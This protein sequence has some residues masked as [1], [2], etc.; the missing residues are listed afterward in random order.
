MGELQIDAAR[1]AALFVRRLASAAGR[2]FERV[3]RRLR[4]DRHPLAAER[5]WQWLESLGAEG[6]LPPQA[7]NAPCPGATA[8]GVHC[9][10]DYGQRSLVA[11]WAIWLADVQLPSGAVPD[12]L[13]NRP[14]SLNTSQAV[15][16]WRRAT[17]SLRVLTDDKSQAV[18][19]RCERAA[20]RAA[21]WLENHG[22]PVGCHDGGP[23]LAAVSPLTGEQLLDLWQRPTAA[24]WAAEALL[25]RGCGDDARRLT[26][27]LAV[28]LLTTT[29]PFRKSTAATHELAHAATLLYRL[30]DRRR[31]SA[32]LQRALVRQQ[33]SGGFLPRASRARPSHAGQNRENAWAAL[34]VLRALQAQVRAAFAGTAPGVEGPLAPDGELADRIGAWASAISGGVAAE[35]GAGRGRW[36]SVLKQT[37]PT[38]D[39]LAIDPA[40]HLWDRRQRAAA[41]ISGSASDLP[42][43]AASL[44]A[45]LAVEVLEH[46]LLPQQALAEMCRVLRPGG[47]LLIV[48]KPLA[49]QA[50]SR[51][52]PWERWFEPNE[53]GDWL[54]ASC[55]DVHCHAIVAPSFISRGTGPTLFIWQAVRKADAS[56]ARA[57]P[58]AA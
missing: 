25:E 54:S 58:R 28:Q 20:A 16:A 1:G 14:S 44:H 27:L 26:N 32:A 7:G 38:V 18:V 53:I 49:R 12:S 23:M 9:A 56:G 29:S 52:E 24:L 31:A 55:E 6:G 2:R 22:G 8:L 50:L 45:V 51:C 15:A 30:G 5:T 34:Q 13:L 41:M 21:I 46:T 47:R 36:F 48:D 35:I 57:Q 33:P 11:Q 37:A 39:W 10:A 3:R 4:N 43:S 40:P 42:L 19:R 17:A